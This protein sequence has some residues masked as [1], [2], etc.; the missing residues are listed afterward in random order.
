MPVWIALFRGINVGGNNKLPMAKLKVGLETL[1]LTNVQTYIQSGNVVFESSSGANAA[2]AKKIS[3]WVEA[4]HGFRP[5]VLLLNREQLEDA[6]KQNPFPEATEEPTSLHF[7][8]LAKPATKADLPALDK[9]KAASESYH[10]T[11]GVFYLKAPDG[12]GRSKLA[13]YAEKY[14]GVV[15]TARNYRTIAKLWTMVS[16]G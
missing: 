1:K 3:D 16:E 13:A 2:L 14:L 9:V 5:Q 15:A 12:V 8:F 7:Y 10:L 6:I 11:D 4:E